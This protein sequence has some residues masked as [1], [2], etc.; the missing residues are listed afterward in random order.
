M[1]ELEKHAAQVDG[2]KVELFKKLNIIQM[3]IDIIDEAAKHAEELDRQATEFEQWV[4]FLMYR[5]LPEYFHLIYCLD[6]WDA[7]I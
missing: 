3:Q 5:A 4:P 6:D 2:G 1:Q 7:F